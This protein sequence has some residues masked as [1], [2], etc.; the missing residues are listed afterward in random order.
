MKGIKFSRKIAEEEGF[1]LLEVMVTLVLIAIIF[2]AFAQVYGIVI[3]ANYK[4]ELTNRAID[5]AQAE[6]ESLKQ[7]GFDLSTIVTD[8]R[9]SVAG[10]QYEKLI[11]IE[12]YRGIE[13]VKKITVTIFWQE[14]GEE[15]SYSLSTVIYN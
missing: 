11:T 10:S 13:D 6:L 3:K 9:L 7:P 5:L 1:T 14:K 4:S 8:E 2:M 12:D 15:K